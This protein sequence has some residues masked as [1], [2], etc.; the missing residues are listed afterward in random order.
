MKVTQARLKE[1]LRY[2][3]ET[4]KFT[5]LVV[6]GGERPGGEAGAVNNAAGHIQIQIDKKIYRAHRLAWLYMTGDWP[7]ALIDHINNLPS[8]NRWANL[9]LATR[10]TNAQN[11]K[12]RADNRS[13]LKGANLNDN[14]TYGSRIRIDGRNIFLGTFLTAQ[15]AHEAYCRAAR[16]YFGEYARAG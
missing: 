7:P 6:R 13:G 16:L 1:L 10:R 4:G 5:W 11:A 14:G 15:E 9:R 8:D 12:T 2:S 3:P